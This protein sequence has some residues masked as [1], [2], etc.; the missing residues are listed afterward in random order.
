[1]R[2]FINNARAICSAQPG[3]NGA[4]Q[5]IT[6]A[7]NAVQN[8]GLTVTAKIAEIAQG[9]QKITS[10]IINAQSISLLIMVLRNHDQNFFVLFMNLLS[11]D[12]L[13][14]LANKK[15]ELINM[16]M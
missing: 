2:F 1:M 15:Y 10:A 8:Q 3:V 16:L 12:A 4:V 7:V 13:T 14:C 6:I 9:D 11:T 5:K